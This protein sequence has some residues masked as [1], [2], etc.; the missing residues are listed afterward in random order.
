MVG[1]PEISMKVCKN[2]SMQVFW[3]QT[4]LTQIL[5]GP[6]FFKLSVPGGLRIFRAFASLFHNWSWDLAGVKIR[7]FTWWKQGWLAHSKGRK[8]E[9]CE[10]SLNRCPFRS[11]G[12]GHP[13]IHRW[14]SCL[15]IQCLALEKQHVIHAL[16]QAAIHT[17]SDSIQWD[18]MLRSETVM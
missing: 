15:P 3:V 8:I 18:T 1:F 4:F 10:A 2:A 14:F 7:F 17:K 5:P 16:E 9:R 12:R 6:N 13:I 11:S